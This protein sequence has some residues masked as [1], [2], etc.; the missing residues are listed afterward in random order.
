MTWLHETV[1]DLDALRKAVHALRV[2]PLGAQLTGNDIATLPPGVRANLPSTPPQDWGNLL[3]PYQSDPAALLV[4]GVIEDA[5][6][7]PLASSVAEWGYVIDLETDVFEVYTGHQDTPHRRGRFA[8]RPTDDGDVPVALAAA[9]PL[10]AL[11][12]PEEFLARLAGGG[13]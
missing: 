9:W 11:P 5:G 8:A 3:W 6:D 2:V 4:I 10:A 1:G 7:F 13:A 12:A